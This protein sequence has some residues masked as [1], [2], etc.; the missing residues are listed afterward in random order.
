VLI[1]SRVVV[2][3]IMALAQVV[4]CLG[5]AV[6][7]RGGVNHPLQTLSALVF[8]FGVPPLAFSLAAR[9]RREA[10]RSSPVPPMLVIFVN[11]LFAG[12]DAAL[13]GGLPLGVL[14]AGLA[15][16]AFCAAFIGTFGR[17]GATR[18]ASEET[19]V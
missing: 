9:V 4:A 1:S 2:A 16:T 11:M 8:L 18:P 7:P 17:S 15:I 6:L 12:V 3:A 13:D 5:V 19:S 10:K 14:A